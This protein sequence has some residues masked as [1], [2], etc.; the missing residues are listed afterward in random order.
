LHLCARDS[1]PVFIR[2]YKIVYDEVLLW[3]ICN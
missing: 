1:A 3:K 2:G